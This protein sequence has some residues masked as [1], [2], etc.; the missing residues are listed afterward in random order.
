MKITLS[1]NLDTLSMNYASA[2]FCVAISNTGPAITFIMAVLLRMESISM[3][4]WPGIAKVVGSAVSILGATLFI[5]VKGP[6]I[7][8]TSHKESSVLITE[9]SSKG[10]WLK[11]SLTA[12]SSNVTW[13]AWTIMQEP[14]LKEYPAKMRLTALQTFFSCI[15]TALW[16]VAG[17][18]YAGLTYWLRIWV[19]DKKGPVF[20]GHFHPIRARLYGLLF[21]NL[22]KESLHWGSKAHFLLNSEQCGSACGAVVL[23]GGLYGYLWGKMNK[24]KPKI[25]SNKSRLL[26]RKLH[27]T[28]GCTSATR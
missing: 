2:T 1:L 11:G 23:V 24:I 26:P 5:L 27:E 16:A 9:S 14:I 18:L 13:A 8:H 4:R 28:V 7:Y 20:S 3:K 10:D 21:C 6:P 15:Q 12:F 22:V 17:A 19:I 25:L